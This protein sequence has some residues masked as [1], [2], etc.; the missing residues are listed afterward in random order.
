M[1][2]RPLSTVSETLQAAANIPLPVDR[3]TLLDPPAPSY[4]ASDTGTS[5]RN[6]NY[7]SPAASSP[8][9][10]TI[11]KEAAQSDEKLPEVIKNKKRLSVWIAYGLI[12]FVVVVLAV[13]LPVYF[14]VIKHNPDPVRSTAP[15]PTGGTQ[16]GKNPPPPLTA[17]VTG[18]DG[19]TVTTDDG[20][21]FIYNNKFGG[22][23]FSDPNDPF[24]N[25]AQP[26]SWTPP[27]NQTWTWGKDRIYGVNL[28]GWF[29]LE[30][31][32]SPAL[33]QKY[34]DATDEWSLSTLMAADTQS[35]GLGQ[36]EEHYKTFI[37]EGDFAAIAGAGLNWIRLPI[38]FWAIDKWDNEPF[39][40]KT[41]W[42]YILR[43]FEWA[44]KYGLRINLDLHTIPGSQNGYNHSGKGGKINFMNGVMGYA[45]AQRTLE[46]IRV[47]TE[48]ISQPQYKDL[49]PLF[50]IMNEAL[51]S[52][53]GKPGLTSFY[54]QVHGMM[55]NITGVGEGNGP[56]ISIHDGFQGLDSWSNFLPGSDR[57]ALDTHPY[58]AFSGGPATDPIATGTGAQAG[59]TWPLAACDRWANGM[60]NSR[61]SF[62]VTYAGEFSNGFNDCGLFLNGVH[63]A[64]SYGGDCGFWQDASGWNDSVKAG[65]K[66]FA[67]ASMDA[68]GDWFFWTWKIANSTAGHPESP[69]W[70]YSLGLEG[71]WM[72]LDPREA[73]GTCATLGVSGQNFDGNYQPWQ[74]GGQGAG[75]IPAAQTAE[76]PWP[77]SSI[78]GA[79]AAVTLLP[80]YTPT[81][82][83]VSL[84]P[85][86]M[87]A[88]S[89]KNVNVGS[90]WYNTGD[91]MPAPTEIAGC[92]YPDAWDAVD[93]AVPPACS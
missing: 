84:P 10:A 29:V 74:T 22:F 88:S 76:F 56:M 1:A 77:P 87:T 14:T 12:V 7:I 71:G 8:L 6:S 11:D 47:I 20:S 93:V 23:W 60:N 64:T 3:N 68:L 54:L 9:L 42:K 92:K 53:I 41:C 31:F 21:T 62:G 34:P 45:N 48:F 91:T 73:S 59:G 43:A 61:S 52:N 58:F 63:G 26:N 51:P 49:I 81:G 65:L 86:T 50:G 70:S 18:G 90:G 46:Y 89:I 13:I 83:I 75:N 69:L 66:H 40:E 2:D 85:P 28:G 4:V 82:S 30:P 36:L 38:P 24:N 17:P 79:G 37:T 16:G 33:F 72:P 32:I 39:L 78:N 35:G 57:I 44:R 5:P 67:M 55:R 25:D 15:A 80:S 27:I 19:S